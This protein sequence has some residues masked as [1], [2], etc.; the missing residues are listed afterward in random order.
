MASTDEELISELE[1]QRQTLRLH[2]A[3]RLLEEH[4]RGTGS[5]VERSLFESY[6]DATAYGRDAFVASLDETLTDA[7][8]WQGGGHVYELG[9]D[10]VSY[11]PSRWH[12]ELRDTPD[13]RE[14][15]R[16][17]GADAM[18]TEGGDREAVTEDGVVKEML[19]DAAVGIGGMTREDARS[20]IR[21]LKAED[22]VREYPAQHANPWIQPI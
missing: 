14:Y 13:L 21:E 22:E 19:L 3:V 6:L 11:Y 18:K 2:E 17:M 20:Q 1:S 5:G 15:L 4:H 12:E 16:V 7:E 10:R 8:T 9:D